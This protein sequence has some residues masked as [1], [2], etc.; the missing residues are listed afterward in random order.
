MVGRRRRGAS[1]AT[2]LA[3]V[4]MLTM[5]TATA[6]A[7]YTM[8]LNFV[9]SDYNSALALCE[10]ESAL[11][12]L[13][14]ELGR[15]ER[16]GTL[17][18]EEIRGRV[19]AA[20]EAPDGAAYHVLTFRSGTGFARSVNNLDGTSSS[21]ALGRTLPAGQV[22]ALATGFCRGRTVT[23]EVLIKHP[24]FPFGLATSGRIL[25]RDPL[26]VKGTS[27][28]EAYREGRED[29]PGHVLANSPDGIVIE[30][31][32]GTPAEQ[33]TN[34]TGFAR[35]AG[36][37]RVAQPATIRGGI[38][39]FF[40]S[41]DLPDVNLADFLQMVEFAPGNLKPGVVA[42]AAS[43]YGSQELDAI[44][45]YRGN[46]R[47]NGSVEMKDAFLVVDGNLD[48][49]GGLRG[50]GAIVATGNIN[51]E[52][53]SSLD[54]RNNVAVL[55]GQD[56][57][58]RG[59]GNYFQGILY[60]EGN[61]VA[62]NVTVVGNSIVNSPTPGKGNVDLQQVTFV[63]DETK[64]DLRFTATSSSGFQGQ[65]R[66]GQSTFGLRASAAG[67]PHYGDVEEAGGG[68]NVTGPDD[69][70]ADVIGMLGFVLATAQGGDAIVLANE[71]Q[72][73]QWSA[74]WVDIERGNL[75][76][77]AYDLAKKA[78]DARQALLD[79][80]DGAKTPAERA[81]ALAE[82][83]RLVA[84]VQTGIVDLARGIRA[85]VHSRADVDGSTT[86]TA[87]ERDVEMNVE[88]DLNRYLPPSEAHRVSFF[89]LHRRKL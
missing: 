48:I 60:S 80:N 34:I 62:S 75:A 2:V 57:T 38:Q 44:Y 7:I 59:G 78:N 15:N 3:I 71:E 69:S 85:Y 61:L 82:H 14:Y 70:E 76:R 12:E 72:M 77:R 29:R 86:S 30:R 89:R 26:V 81:A 1:L 41:S 88:V 65:P 66:D 51:L 47:Y 55:A 10:A 39:P 42:I 31:P 58:V 54:G 37:I 83:E 43:E 20:S 23:L 27:S 25:S 50:R 64:G 4:M 22:H 53:G 56:L 24:P 49:I 36:D 16:F 32:G 74:G 19:T 5:L 35:S 13:L 79:S 84:E 33:V 67:F 45:F 28:A 8:T 9:Q 17:G 73:A 46:L 87:L 6:T 11:H 18:T 63:S 68:D 40:G 52:G 21:G